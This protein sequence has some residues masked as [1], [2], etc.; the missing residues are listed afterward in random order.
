MLALRLVWAGHHTV[1]NV[2]CHRKV[3][4]GR[5]ERG[6]RDKRPQ[7][8]GGSPV[9]GFVELSSYRTYGVSAGLDCE[10][11]PTRTAWIGILAILVRLDLDS[12]RSP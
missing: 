10:L 12:V 8:F 9:G 3:C 11:T 1:P 5:P 2:G 6:H 4:L 7:T